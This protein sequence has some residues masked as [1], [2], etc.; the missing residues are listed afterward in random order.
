MLSLRQALQQ[1]GVASLRDLAAQAGIHRG[2]IRFRTRPCPLSLIWYNTA[3]KPVEV[4]YT[5]GSGAQP[6]HAYHGLCPDLD[7]RDTDL[8]CQTANRDELVRRILDSGADAVGLCE[9]FDDDVR[10]HFVDA[11]SAIY[12]PVWGPD[13][14]GDDLQESGL[15]LLT[16]LP[17]LES[18]RFVFPHASFPDGLASKG[19][20]HVRLQLDDPEATPCDLVFTHLQNGDWDVNKK[21]CS[22]V[23]WFAAAT[24]SIHQPC[25][26]AGDWNNKDTHPNYEE[27]LARAQSPAD[28]WLL[29]DPNGKGSREG[30]TLGLSDFEGRP[31]KDSPERVDYLFARR[32][33]RKVAVPDRVTVERWRRGGRL[34]VSDHFGLRADFSRCLEVTSEAE[35]SLSRVEG[36][37]VRFRALRE[38]SGVGSDEICITLVLRGAD[39]ASESTSLTEG[40]MDSGD[41]RDAP[42][43]DPAVLM[44]HPGE[45]LTL[46]LDMSEKDVIGDDDVLSNAELHIPLQDL[47]AGAGHPVLY[48]LPRLTGDGADYAVE[49][50]ITAKL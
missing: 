16:R 35:G 41:S 13:E 46:L 38:T 44:G 2:P 22:D 24:S 33:H 3:M 29:A 31:A 32:G 34:D 5:L 43:H 12:H 27:M 1:E 10:G 49:V 11:T 21:Q 37:I 15:L 40:D 42:H 18:H 4:P 30:A 48:T 9:L 17:V 8:D 39:G 19:I 26:L 45:S 28:L 14:L 36:R 7:A 23:G 25:L 47:L 6:E 50:E 20:L